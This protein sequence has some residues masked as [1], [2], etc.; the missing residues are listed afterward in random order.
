MSKSNLP[1][2]A[3]GWKAGG[4]G[5]TPLARSPD[6]IPHARHPLTDER[7]AQFLEAYR[8]TGSVQKAA[9]L[10]D[11][12]PHTRRTYL[13]AM[14]RDLVFGRACEDIFESWKEKV[15]DVLKEEFFEGVMVPVVNSKGLVLDPATK[16]PMYVRKRDSKIVLAYA[17]KFDFG[18]REIKTTI[19]VDAGNP[20]AADPNDPQFIVKSSD[21]HRLPQADMETLKRLLQ[22]VHANRRETMAEIAARP[23]YLEEYLDAED[24]EYHDVTPHTDETNPYDI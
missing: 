4:D 20:N 24:V 14:A 15:A 18:L 3:K 5:K 16:K 19:N 2:K 1:D 21:L 10:V 13:T 6:T 12:S 22:Q 9:E 11:G 23:D 8:T 17:K 7:K